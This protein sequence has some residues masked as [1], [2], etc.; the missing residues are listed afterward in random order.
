MRL[1]AAKLV[2]ML[3]LATPMQTIRFVLLLASTHTGAALEAWGDGDNA[4]RTQP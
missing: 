1:I 2:Q 3:R 4:D